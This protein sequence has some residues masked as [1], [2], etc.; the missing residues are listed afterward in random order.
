MN[1]NKKFV[2]ADGKRMRINQFVRR[3]EPGQRREPRA[4]GGPAVSAHELL[5][6][7]VLLT[8]AEWAHTTN[9]EALLK[10]VEFVSLRIACPA[11]TIRC[12]VHTE[13]T[14]EQNHRVC[15]HTISPRRSTRVSQVYTEPVICIREQYRTMHSMTRNRK[16]T[17]TS[18]FK[19][20]AAWQ[21]I[22]S[23]CRPYRE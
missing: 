18:R 4:A 7:D 8:A 6:A 10:M 17:E 22:P 20:F 5:R 15:R 21:L 1:R 12:R 2:L 16:M 11:A 14:L 19:G 9:A 3:N 23:P 13:L